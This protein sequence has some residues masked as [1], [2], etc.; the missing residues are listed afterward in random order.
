MWK[1]QDDAVDALFASNKTPDLTSLGDALVQSLANERVKKTSFAVV[2]ERV[3]AED[4]NQ[5]LP[6][7]KTY[8]EA[9][10]KFTQYATAFIEH[11][12]LLTKARAAYE[13]ATSASREMRKVLD[14]GDQKLRT[15][16]TRL[17]REG[18]IQGVTPDPDKKQPEPEK[19]E[20]I[21][22]ADGSGGRA[23]RWP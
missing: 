10:D 12:P 13:E 11:L 9:M 23:S 2:P 17:E 19:P 15:L 20:S 4:Q 7:M 21:R 6:T 18:V 3:L 1:K 14:N 5:P 22:E 16:M 8:T